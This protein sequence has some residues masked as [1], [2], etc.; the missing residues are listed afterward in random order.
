MSQNVSEQEVD[1]NLSIP[2]NYLESDSSLQG[3]L[4]SLKDVSFPD[5]SVDF[6]NKNPDSIFQKKNFLPTVTGQIN[7]GYEYGLLT[8]Y[9]D[10]NSISPLS[11]F[12]TRGD[13]SVEALGLPVN[14]SYNYSNFLNPLGVNNYVRCSVDT[15]R[16][17]Q[18]GLA[19]KNEAIGTLDNQ[20]GELQNKKNAIQGKLGMGEVFLQKYKREM[21]V[22]GDRMTSYENQI[23]QK[24]EEVSSNPIQGIENSN[25]IQNQKEL[26]SLRNLYEKA[27]TQYQRAIELYDTINKTYNR[28]MQVYTMYT[29]LQNELN[30]KKSQLS[31]LSILAN[32]ENISDKVSSQKNGFIS[33][34]KTLD[35]GLTYPKTTGL[36]KNSVP[37]QGVNIEM[38]KEN[39]YLAFS[40]GVTMNN[41]MVSTDAIQNKLNNSANLFNQFDFQNI[42]ERGWLTNVKT[43]YGLPE[44][45]HFY[46]GMRYLT[47]SIPLQGSTDSAAVPTLGNEIDIR[48]IPAFSKGTTVDVI[49]GKTSWRNALVDSSRTGVFNSLYSNDR[50]NTTLLSLTQDLRKVRSTIQGSVRW[51]D[52]YADVRSLGVLQPDNLRYE[53]RTTTNV[54][55]GIRIGLNYRHD[56]NN[57]ISTKDTTVQLNVVGGQLNGTLFKTITYFTSVNYLTQQLNSSD[58]QTKKENYMFG[59]G[60]SSSYELGEVKNTFSISYNDYLITDSVSTGLFRNISLQNASKFSFGINKFSVGFFQMKDEILLD[61][62]SY[63]IGDEFSMQKKKLKLTLGM[64][65]SISDKY[66]TQLGGKMEASYRLTKHLEWTIKAERMVLGDFYNYYSRDR[67]DKFPYALMTRIGWTF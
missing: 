23:K 49:Y 16:L 18:N 12:N 15:D 1:E 34:L 47:N 44:E 55:N 21:S 32:T 36:S 40:S 17:K 65:V 19:K 39:W 41:L 52:P 60:I 10:P 50:T 2:V 28:A 22:Y 37:I 6:S 24:S 51:I 66:G 45:T 53:F 35:L 67:F 7:A 62:T 54:T 64:K 13:L 29:N 59:V 48:W 26:D 38:Q 8:G 20:L 56:Q 63:I 27:Q 14:L 4:N 9:V 43:G 58:G 42:K 25:K 31:S 61:N 30:T 33:S 5:F 11:V 46:I 3:Y 57:L